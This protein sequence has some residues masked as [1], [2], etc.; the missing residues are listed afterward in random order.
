[1][2]NATNQPESLITPD[3]GKGDLN[4]PEP[5]PPDGHGTF[6]DELVDRAPA[7]VYRIVYAELATLRE[8]A[9]KWR[10]L[11]SRGQ[12]CVLLPPVKALPR[13]FELED[14]DNDN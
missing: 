8:E 5:K 1:M 10:E 9:A 3:D 2:P 6:L 7:N 4:K 14:D 13:H 11:K 12:P